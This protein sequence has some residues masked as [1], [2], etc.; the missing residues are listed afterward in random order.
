MQTDKC[1]HVF[2]MGSTFNEES[3]LVNK[4]KAGCNWY[5]FTRFDFCPFCGENL[6]EAWKEIENV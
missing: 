2:G 6:T 1:F 4:Y 3:E 5:Y